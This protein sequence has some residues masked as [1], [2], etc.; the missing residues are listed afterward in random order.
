LANN[1]MLVAACGAVLLGT[2]YPLALDALGMGKISVGPPYFETV[3]VPLMAPV[4]FLM[5]VGPL[6]R[7]K[8][9]ELPDLARRLRW[10]LLVAVVATGLQALYHVRDAGGISWL[11]T[12]GLLMAWWV[13]ASLAADAWERLRPRHLG[14]VSLATRLKAVPRAFAERAPL[15]PRSVAAM[16]VAHLGI[17]VFIFGVTMVKTFEVERDVKMAIGDFV[18][19]DD[20]TFTL[21]G[22]RERDGPNF[23]AV[24]G[25]VE[26]TRG[27]GAAKEKVLDLLPEKRVYRVQDNPMTEAAISTRLTQDLY[28]SLGEPVDDGRAWIVRIYIKPFVDWIWGGCALMALGGLLAAGDRRYRQRLAAEQTSDAGLLQAPAR[29][30]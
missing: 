25:W 3:F 26:V 13:V 9:A 19:I 11:A 24:Q 6:A 16:W 8:Q 2:L 28:V 27:E 23:R 12:L 30:A 14:P 5:G 15:V 20:L 29:R 18:T 4:V 10:A 22:L 17:A 1:V 7:W 21:Q